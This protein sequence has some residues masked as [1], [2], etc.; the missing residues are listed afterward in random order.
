LAHIPERDWSIDR[1]AAVSAPAAA[2]SDV[3][4]PLPA[5]SCHGS[6]PVGGATEKLAEKERKTLWVTLFVPGR[7][8]QS[9][10]STHRVV[11]AWS[12]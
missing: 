1:L 6:L 5:N 10:A 12:L 7:A 9:N 4:N 11:M 8:D 2:S 3:M